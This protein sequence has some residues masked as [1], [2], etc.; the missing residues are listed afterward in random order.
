MEP[1]C[2]DHNATTPTRPEVVQA[3]VDCYRQGYANPASQHLLGQ[4]AKRRLED[5]R[6]AIGQLLGLELGG[7]T[8]DRLIFTSGGT[9]SN[10][11]AIFGITATGGGA[12][13]RI[14]ISAI[15]HASVIEPAEHLLDRGWRLDSLGVDASGAARIERLDPLLAP[16][17]RLVCVTL[18]NHDTGVVQPV[19]ELA[20]ICRSRGVPMHT[21]AVQAAG[22]LPIDFRRLGVDALSL[23]AHKFQG[24]PGIGA[25]A[26]RGGVAIRPIHYG[27]HQQ[28]GLRPGTEPIPLVVGML[29]ALEVSQRERQACLRRLEALRARFE[30]GLRRAVPGLLV[31]GHQAQR[32]PHVSNLAFSGLDAQLLL[33]ALDQ[34]GIACSVG[35]ACASG[36]VELSPTLL[37][38][39]LPRDIVRASLRFSLGADTSQEDIDEAVRRIVQVV[40]SVRG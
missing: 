4:K 21:D 40:R 37:A 33:M 16:E 36:S 3:M 29:A 39:G 22:K 34:V 24:P 18:A 11:L 13:G 7:R 14:V 35:S 6:E 17:T 8:P 20:A 5:A 32:L 30:N 28:W 38:M 31:H 2:L 27:G 25:L 9:E 12:P 1:I 10:C 23:A 26:L 19:A 15:E